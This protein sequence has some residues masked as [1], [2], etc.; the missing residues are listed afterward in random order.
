MTF[1][2]YLPIMKQKIIKLLAKIDKRKR[3]LVATI[4]LTFQMLVFTFL[5]FE[6]AMVGLP[7][8]LIVVYIASFFAILEGID[9][10]EYIML[11]L[12]PIYFTLAFIMFYFFLPQRWL[13][14]LPVLMIYGVSMYAILLSQNIFNVGVVKSL[15]LFRAAYS[16]NYLFLT[17]IMFLTSSLLFSFR[18]TFIENALGVFFLSV[19]LALHLLWSVEPKL[20][21]EKKI[22]QLSFVIGIIIA[23]VTIVGSFMPLNSAIFALLTTGV[24]Y[25]LCGLFA[26]DFSGRLFRDR[27]REYVFVMIFIGIITF[28]S[29]GW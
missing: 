17:I 28:L 20:I 29:L 19:P 21:I 9:R 7:I 27:V 23:E 4:V 24:Y 3:F 5:G 18:L 16:V 12:V 25:S 1:Q 14:R 15:Q 10:G 6:T 8:A 11:F 13:T 2:K 26:A 22:I